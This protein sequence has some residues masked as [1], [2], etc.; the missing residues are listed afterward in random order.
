MVG[1]ADVPMQRQKGEK[2]RVVVGV[3]NLK[4]M[5]VQH[6]A[7]GVGA[8]TCGEPKSKSVAHLARVGMTYG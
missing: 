6:L 8:T 3:M 1:G 4:S 5:Q 2:R 7:V